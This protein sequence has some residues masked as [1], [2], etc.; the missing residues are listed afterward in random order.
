MAN[1]LKLFTPQ[2]KFINAQL[3]MFKHAL[4]GNMSGQIL[5]YYFLKFLIKLVFYRNVSVSLATLFY[6]ILRCKKCYMISPK[7]VC[8]HALF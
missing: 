5:T 4:I 8:L 3:S 1:T 7:T 6:T 2:G